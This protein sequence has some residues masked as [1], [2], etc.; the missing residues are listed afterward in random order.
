[1]SDPVTNHAAQQIA[2][3]AAQQQARAG[4]AL[5]RSAWAADPGQVAPGELIPEDLKVD[6]AASV[7]ELRFL[8]TPYTQVE[9]KGTLRRK[10]IDVPRLSAHLGT[11]RINGQATPNRIQSRDGRIEGSE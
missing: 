8:K 10:V 11:G 1:M 9:L 7:A 2:N 4:F 3:Q 6:L 5:V